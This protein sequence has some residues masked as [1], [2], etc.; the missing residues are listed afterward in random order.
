MEERPSGSSRVE[1]AMYGVAV[2]GLIGFG[3]LLTTPILNWICGPAFVVAVVTLGT[4][5]V[6]RLLARRRAR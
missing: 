4:P 6:E 2:L 3:I 1:L 5:R